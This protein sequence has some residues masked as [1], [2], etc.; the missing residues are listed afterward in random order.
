[1]GK[2]FSNALTIC[3]A[4]L[5][6]LS[7]RYLF[8]LQVKQDLSCGRLTCNDTSAALM[9][10]H[11]IQCKFLPPQALYVNKNT[12]ALTSNLFQNNTTLYYYNTSYYHYCNT[13]Y[14]TLW[15]CEPAAIRNLVNEDRDQ[16]NLMRA[17]RYHPLDSPQPLC[18]L[19]GSILKTDGV[20][21]CARS[22]GVLLRAFLLWFIN[23]SI[24]FAVWVFF[25]SQYFSYSLV[26]SS[27]DWRLWGEPVSVA[28]PQQ[29]LHSRSNAPD[30]QDHGVPFKEHVSFS[31]WRS[32]SQH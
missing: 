17:P 9:V 3:P 32:V 15:V 4:H 31:S 2:C 6:L 29:Q 30:W 13:E 12:G 19:W 23:L 24:F 27:W 7:P 5:V 14:E 28:P 16:H 11:I 21:H 1:M 18:A 22:S 25:L 10:S 20:T 8:A 26:F